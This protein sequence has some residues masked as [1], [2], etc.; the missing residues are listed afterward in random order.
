MLDRN[1]MSP[2]LGLLSSALTHAG[3]EPD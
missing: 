3:G 2:N 1:S